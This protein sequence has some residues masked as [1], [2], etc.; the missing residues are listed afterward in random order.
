MFRNKLH[1]YFSS[2]RIRGTSLLTGLCICEL[3]NGRKLKY[4]NKPFF[5]FILILRRVL[6]YICFCLIQFELTAVG[7]NST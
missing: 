4:E 3:R 7:M 6:F 2:L 5:V 1:K